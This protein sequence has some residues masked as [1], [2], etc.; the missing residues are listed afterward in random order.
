MGKKDELDNVGEMVDEL[1]AEVG[2]DRQRLISFLDKLVSEYADSPGGIAEF[3]AKL[4]EASTHQ[5]QVKVAV[6]K[7]LSSR[8]TSVEDENDENADIASE[9][10]MP[11][12]ETDE[13]SN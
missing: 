10:G 5:H 3:V 13:S 2:E 7:A 8:K 9:I 1:I 6:V 4:I 11:F 12:E